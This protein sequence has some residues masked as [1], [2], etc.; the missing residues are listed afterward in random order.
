MCQADTTFLGFK[1]ANQYYEYNVLP[2]GLSS[3][4]YIFSKVM[5]EIVK[6]WRGRGIKIVMYLDDGLGGGNGFDNALE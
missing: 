3:S 5:R 1:W 6:H 4:G 2:F